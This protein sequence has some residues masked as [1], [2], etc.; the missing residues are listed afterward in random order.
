VRKVGLPPAVLVC[1]P[2]KNTSRWSPA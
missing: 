2:T 1:I